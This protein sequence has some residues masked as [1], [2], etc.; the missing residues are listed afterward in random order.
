MNCC[1]SSSELQ[2]NMITQVIINL[3]RF[4]QD[5]GGIL[6][7]LI[8]CS[9]IHR[10]YP[11]V[12]RLPLRPRVDCILYDCHHVRDQVYHNFDKGPY[13]CQSDKGPYECQSWCCVVNLLKRKQRVEQ[14]NISV[15]KLQMPGIT[16]QLF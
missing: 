16:S 9:H 4:C 8:L 7:I 11:L 3:P 5:N 1:Q 2:G 13:E 15:N 14:K 6:P 12:E 10:H